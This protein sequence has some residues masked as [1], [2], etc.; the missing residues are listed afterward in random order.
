MSAVFFAPILTSVS[1]PIFAQPA[2]NEKENDINYVREVIWR[3]GRVRQSG[4]VPIR[5]PPPTIIS[6]I[7]NAQSTNVINN[8]KIMDRSVR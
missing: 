8:V 2:D 5:M 4:V 6:A 1:V 3:L 7:M